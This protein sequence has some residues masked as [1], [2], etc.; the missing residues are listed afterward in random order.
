MITNL[1][2]A[3][4]PGVALPVADSYITATTGSPTTGTYTDSGINYKYYSFTGSGSI[5]FAKSGLVDCLI[6]GGGGGGSSFGGGGAGGYLSKT[7]AYLD[8]GTLTVTVGAGG[9][10][11]NIGT[12]S[13]I[14]NTFFSFGGGFGTSTTL[15]ASQGGSGG[16]AADSGRGGKIGNGVAG[17]GFNGALG[18]TDLATYTFKWC[19]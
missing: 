10:A 13:S 3:T 9:S 7:S 12:S 8:S 19:C 18:A 14:A 17:Q 16:G 2:K 1:N 4:F 6:I 5:T 11:V 15:T